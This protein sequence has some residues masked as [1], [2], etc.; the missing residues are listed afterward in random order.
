M[1]AEAL[2]EVKSVVT[3][4]TSDSPSVNNQDNEDGDDDD[5]AEESVSKNV[6]WK[7]FHYFFK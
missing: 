2:P 7:P 4:T 3:D 1:A 5:E 6:L